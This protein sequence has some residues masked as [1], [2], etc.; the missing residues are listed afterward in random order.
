MLSNEEI[1]NTYLNHYKHSQ[2]SYN[3]RKSSLKYFFGKST[4]NNHTE[5]RKAFNYQGHV[6]DLTT[7]KLIDY[8]DWLKAQPISLTT[9]KN[10]WNIMVS[11]LKSTMEY[12]R[13]YNFIVIIP[14]H[15]INWGTKHQKP[16]SNKKVIATK[17]EISKL[18]EYF[19][20]YNHKHYLM[21]RLLTETGMRKGGL[22]SLKY[23]DVYT[24]KRYLEVYEKNSREDP[25][26]YYFS[27]NLAAHL[28]MYIKKRKKQVIKYDNLFLTKNKCK[29]GTSTF[30]LILKMARDKAEIDS[31]ITCHTF[32]RTL[33]T[34]RKKMG[35]SNE[36]RKILLNHKTLDVNYDS[37]TILEYDTFIHLYD[38]W[39][40][41]K[42]LNL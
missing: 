38:T 26:V 4:K 7:D 16:N 36:N 39:N 30:N 23:E 14:K 31:K 6:F 9:K 34:L 40:P 20:M 19:K 15:S 21:F 3:L 5:E 10:K 8:F 11:F 29:Y 18:L 33:N 37:Y 25:N 12:F 41:Y 2:Q 17:E 42:E 28:E 24:Q 27:E 1:I 22:I 13:K 35:C 32:R